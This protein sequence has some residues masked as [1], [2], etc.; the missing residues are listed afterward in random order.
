M[1]DVLN[2]EGQYSVT[3]DGMI[4]SHKSNKF[5]RHTFVKNYA[6]VGLRDS[7]NGQERKQ[8]L[9]HRLVAESYI[10]NPD[11]K[12]EV[13]HINSDRTDNRA[14]NLEWATR[15]E[16]NSHAWKHGNK[17]FKMTDSHISRKSRKLT[18]DQ[19]QEIRTKYAAGGINQYQ[20]AKHYNVT[21]AT[22]SQIVR[23]NNY[24]AA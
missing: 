13:N 16:N 19:A 21:Q 10:P 24:G 17:V 9:V 5:L 22:V 2:Y 12:P 11:D 7:K 8:Y 6:R 18:I 3:R 4:W 20:L 1:R 23:G 14:K 15:Q